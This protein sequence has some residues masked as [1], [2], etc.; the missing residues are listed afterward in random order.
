MKNISERLAALEA[1]LLSLPPGPFP[2]AGTQYRMYHAIIWQMVGSLSVIARDEYLNT[3]EHRHAR[4][5]LKLIEDIVEDE[6][7][8]SLRLSPDQGQSNPQTKGQNENV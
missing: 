7:K 2:S 8:R 1:Y 4:W 5:A 3:A 6:K